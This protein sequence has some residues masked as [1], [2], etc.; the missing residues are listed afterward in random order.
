MFTSYLLEEN[1]KRDFS[2]GF[3]EESLR[4]ASMDSSNFAFTRLANSSRD[5]VPESNSTNLLLRNSSKVGTVRTLNWVAVRGHVSMFIRKTLMRPVSDSA[6]DSR[7][8]A[9]M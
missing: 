8:G 6:I 7:I 4:V 5:I 1:T 3:G 9:M 2:H